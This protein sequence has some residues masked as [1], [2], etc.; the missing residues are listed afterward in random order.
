MTVSRERD[1]RVR[2]GDKQTN[3]QTATQDRAFRYHEMG[4]HLGDA[5][6]DPRAET[7]R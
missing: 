5:D 7:G 3:K 2:H 4:T 6:P 1:R